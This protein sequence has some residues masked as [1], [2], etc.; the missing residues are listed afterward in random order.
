MS[1]FTKPTLAIVAATA[2]VS[3]GCVSLALRNRAGVAPDTR[4]RIQR[5]AR[6]LG[7]EINSAASLLAQQR[8]AKSR[9][10]N[11]LNIGL[12]QADNCKLP[13]FE[14]ACEKLGMQPVYFD[15]SSFK[16]PEQAEKQLWYK[17][18]TGIVIRTHNF[19]WDAELVQRFNWSRFSIVKIGRIVS[20]LP[21]HLVR[22]SPF[23]YMAMAIDQVLAK[24]F[25][26]IAIILNQSE[27]IHDDTARLGALLGYQA[28]RVGDNV[29]IKWRVDENA[30][31]EKLSKATIDWLKTQDAE[32]LITYHWKQIEPLL[33]AGFKIP[34][35]LKM[36][37]LLGMASNMVPKFPH[38][39]GCDSNHAEL[40]SRA[41]DILRNQILYGE[42]G[43][44]THPMEHV[45]EPT[46]VVGE[47]LL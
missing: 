14:S 32:V 8:K 19:P 31:P 24:N 10:T 37:A 15:I 21:V 2:G 39:T 41:M 7:Y 4:A 16:S 6:D 28:L 20:F 35:H 34:S 11:Q 27:S 36:V 1:N 17:G 26:K 5:V 40:Y 13:A 18:I 12:L 3:T 23:D 44:P 29:S 43:F 42:R 47:T 33:K 9:S 46:W 25:H 30:E 45:I 38:V 22:H